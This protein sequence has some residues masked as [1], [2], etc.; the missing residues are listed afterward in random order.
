MV[1][2]NALAADEAARRSRE[3]ARASSHQQLR[4]LPEPRPRPLLATAGKLQA[5]LYRDIRRRIPRAAV[6]EDEM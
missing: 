5:R 3:L 1:T 4:Q 6:F 2:Y